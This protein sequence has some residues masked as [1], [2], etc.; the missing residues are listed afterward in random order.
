MSNAD[1]TQRLFVPQGM[2]WFPGLAN[3][4][5]GVNNSVP[6][7]TYIDT[8]GLRYIEVEISWTGLSVAQADDTYFK[9]NGTA[10]SPLTSKALAPS[11]LEGDGYVY[12]SGSA[13]DINS[14]VV[15]HT[16]GNGTL[17]A[18]WNYPTRFVFPAFH[19][20]NVSTAVSSNNIIV[21]VYGNV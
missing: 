3:W 18:R 10:E 19:I 4:S 12:S 15:D 7:A 17:I 5:A 20:G 2:V 16:V 13:I 9:L 6:L 8:S 14:V 1:P 21:S 11:S